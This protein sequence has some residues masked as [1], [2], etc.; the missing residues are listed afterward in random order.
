MMKSTHNATLGSFYVSIRMFS[1]MSA[2]QCGLAIRLDIEISE[3]EE[4]YHGIQSDPISEHHRVI[5]F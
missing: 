3:H 1:A 2:F 5:A 4:E